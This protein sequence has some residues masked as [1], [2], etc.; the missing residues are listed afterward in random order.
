MTGALRQRGRAAPAQR[1]EVGTCT[2]LRRA[3]ECGQAAPWVFNRAVLI[4]CTIF[5]TDCG[6]IPGQGECC[7]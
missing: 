7:G 4:D 2:R 6:S 5:L 3:A 1:L